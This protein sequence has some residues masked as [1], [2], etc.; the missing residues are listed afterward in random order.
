MNYSP[1]TLY[2]NMKKHACENLSIFWSRYVCGQ[3]F[4]K[5]ELYL[6]QISHTS[7]RLQ[8]TIMIEDDSLQPSCALWWFELRCKIKNHFKSECINS[9]Y[10]CD[11]WQIF[12]F[13]KPKKFKNNAKFFVIFCFVK[14]DL[15]LHGFFFNENRLK[16]FFKCKSCQP[17]PYE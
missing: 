14:I 7:H 5:C 4:P 11:P 6:K 2:D 12:F 15:W 16:F 17:L 3:T 8:L 9:F 1:L 13:F 10:K